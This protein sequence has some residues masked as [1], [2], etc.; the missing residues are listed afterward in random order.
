M[1]YVCGDEHC[2]SIL[3][4]YLSVCVCLCL[5]CPV[6]HRR[7]VRRSLT[8]LPLPIRS[9]DARSVGRPVLAG[10]LTGRQA[11]WRRGASHFLPSLPIPTTMLRTL[12]HSCLIFCSSRLSLYLQVHRFSSPLCRPSSTSP[13]HHDISLYFCQLCSYLCEM[14]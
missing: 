10:R 13:V 12:T 3:S 1:K 11:R 14:R 7:V 5:P 6:L 8:W 4:V 2:P 9:G